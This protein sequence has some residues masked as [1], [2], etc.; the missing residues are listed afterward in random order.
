MASCWLVATDSPTRSILFCR[1][2]MCF[3]CMISTAARC[4]A[5]C[6]G[7]THTVRDRHYDLWLMDSHQT[8]LQ[9]RGCGKGVCGRVGVEDRGTMV[10]K[11]SRARSADLTLHA[12]GGGGLSLCKE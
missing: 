10:S 12:G 11:D 1:M 4:S 8:L 2:M 6:M 3:S 5:V 7:H 9:G